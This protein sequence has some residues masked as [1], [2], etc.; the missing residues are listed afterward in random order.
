[1]TDTL[2]VLPIDQFFTEGSNLSIADEDLFFKNTNSFKCLTQIAVSRSSILRHP[3]YPFPIIPNPGLEEAIEYEEPEQVFDSIGC[4]NYLR[5]CKFH[6]IPVL[7]RVLSSLET[8]ELNLKYYGLREKQVLCIIDTLKRNKY[9]EVV[10]LQDNWLEPKCLQHISDMLVFNST[11][12]KLVLRECRIKPE[13]AE[14][15]SEG[16]QNSRALV[17]LDLSCNNLG[18]EG[19]AFLEMGLRES[20]SIEILNLSDNNLES[21]S[22]MILSR[23]IA[24]LDVLEEL[25][26]SWNE[27]NANSKGNKALFQ[28][29]SKS[30]RINKL[31]LAWNGISD[32]DLTRAIAVFLRTTANLLHFD[33]SNNRLSSDSLRNIV[34]G[35]MRCRNLA[36][37]KIGNNII[38]PDQA[39]DLLKLFRSLQQLSEINLENI[40]VNKD[41]VPL[42]TALQREGKKV[43]IGSV[44]SN[45]V[46]KGPDKILLLF[47]RAKFL[48]MKAKKKKAQVDFGHFILQLPEN[49][50]SPS[51][52]AALIKKFKMKKIDAD[53]IAAIVN[54]FST[55]KKM[56][57]CQGIRESYM[58]Y[59]PNT[60]LPPPK[61]SKKGKEKKGKKK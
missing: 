21:E 35:L 39:L 58:A 54:Q 13:G 28:A 52:F 44:L 16:L 14:L 2:T 10:D 37:L 34:T 55:P 50:L 20:G 29:L 42:W 48:A 49:D 59:F 6:N 3:L 25:D 56:V 61:P 30:T 11:I 17:E 9:I 15:L 18:D 51:D 41:F 60:V 53:L 38:E 12:R 7:R 43:I 5:L 46:I 47:N 32:K 1:M 31:V 45:Y 40:C 8:D 23:I 26:L 22:G 57:S 27:F 4:D 24:D 19:M 33:I 36:V